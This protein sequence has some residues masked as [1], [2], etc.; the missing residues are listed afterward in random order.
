MLFS[1]ITQASTWKDEILYFVMLD[2]FAD[3]DST[4]NQD[5]DLNNTL[6]FHGGDL[7][8]LREQLGEVKELGAT[9]IWIT[10]I[11]QQVTHPISNQGG[12]FYPHHGYWANDFTQVD[13][14]Y[15]S[16]QDLKDLVAAAHGLGMKVILDIVYNHVGYGADWEK[17]KP[18]WLRAGGQC[19]GSDVTLC[20]S[21][22][23]DLRTELP[24]VRQYLFDAH[25]GLAERTGI[26]GFRLDTVMHVEHGF[27]QA[28]RAEVRKRLGKDFL[29]LGEVWGADKFT[30]R[31]Y[32]QDDEM[33]AVFD[34]TFSDHILG[35]LNGLGSAKRLGRYLSRRHDVAADHFLAPFLS[36]HD[37]PTLLAM[38]RGDVDRYLLAATLLFSVEGMPVI[39]W[40]EE[41]GRTGKVWPYNRE[42]MAWS[43]PAVKPNA[44]WT[45]N[46]FVRAKYRALINL[47]HSNT[48]LRG[49]LS[50]VSYADQDVLALKRGE[51]TVLV[52]NRSDHGV[53]W[54]P[55]L[56]K[57]DHWRLAFSSGGDTATSDMISAREARIYIKEQY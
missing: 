31:P 13:P 19:G 53:K 42:D 6:A 41:V 37:M 29:L 8:G 40:G 52:I 39:T 55:E 4:N 47:R 18:Q 21:G 33:D 9:A 34:F 26:D 15:G 32:F 46:E 48:D 43:D 50:S 17:E 57:P 5:V 22:L 36:N 54:P 30:A 11:N 24:E 44:S 49:H 38:L 14:R 12:P 1:A 28:H 10:P 27:W 16:E 20:L 45:R 23:P 3:G 7:K 2:R 35:Y 51:K 25:I 56:G